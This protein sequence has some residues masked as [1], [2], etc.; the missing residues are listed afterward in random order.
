M[1]DIK[2]IIGLI[3]L[4]VLSLAVIYYIIP[5]ADA[6]YRIEQ[7]GVVY[8]ND[9]VDISGVA[10]GI[11]NLAYYGGFDEESG[12]QFL[13]DVPYTKKGLYNYYIDPTIYSGRLGKWYKWNG[14]YES[15]GNTL[16]FVVVAHRK[17]ILNQ[18]ENESYINPEQVPA[19]LPKTPLLPTRHVSDYLI[20]RGNGFSIPVNGKT[21]VWI[22]GSRDSLLDYQSFNG[23]V[24]ITPDAINTLSPGLYKVLLQTRENGTGESTIRYNAE[25]GNIEWFNPETFHLNYYSVSDNTPENAMLKLQEILPSVHD[26]YKMFNLEIQYPTLSINRIDALNVLNQTGTP[27]DQG[28]DLDEPTYMDVRGYTNVAPDTIVKVI[29]DADFNQNDPWKNAVATKTEG[30]F[31]G[32][33][34]VFKVI[35]PLKL[36]NMKPGR[37]FVSAKSALSEATISTAEFY[38]YGNPEGNLIPNKTIRYISGKY[39]PEE[40]IPTPTP[41]TVTQIVTRVVTQIVTVPVTP[42]NEQVYAQQKVASE[43]TWWEGTTLLMKVI[44]SGTFLISGIWYGISVYRRLKQ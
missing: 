17:P 23:S 19:V 41:I 4:A 34:R 10:A 21:N 44:G 31:G 37:H 43:K 38:V 26:T 35:I 6:Y 27:R 5:P 33:M 14:A 12:T 1:R 39:G 29:V 28:V 32:D 11:E 2:F 13:L 18:T 22:F 15:N 25:T 30:E 20:A 36:I 40:L 8:L 42:S 7:G 9:T 16:A 24:D 3:I